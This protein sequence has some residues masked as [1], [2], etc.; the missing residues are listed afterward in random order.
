MTEAL[1]DLVNADPL[2]AWADLPVLALDGTPP[3]H[4]GPLCTS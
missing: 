1:L 4:G 2:D 3:G